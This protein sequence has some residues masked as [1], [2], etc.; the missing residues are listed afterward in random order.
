MQTFRQYCPRCAPST[1]LCLSTN[2]SSTTFNGS[3]AV[4]FS[5]NLSNANT[6]T[7]LQTFSSGLTLSSTTVPLNMA[8]MA[9]APSA[10]SSGAN[11]YVRNNTV[12]YQIAGSANE[13]SF[14]GASTAVANTWTARQTFSAGTTISAPLA[15][16]NVT[17][18]TIDH[19]FK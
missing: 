3:A 8:L 11:I 13:L 15:T 1:P 2:P 18:V 4:T 9:A 19:C 7:A 12:Y 6:W 5:L 16:T 10:P 17:S 14:G